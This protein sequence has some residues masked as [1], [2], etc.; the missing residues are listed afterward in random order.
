MGRAEGSGQ[1]GVSGRN[2]SV[3]LSC[4]ERVDRR[5]RFAA[6]AGRVRGRLPINQLT[7]F[8]R[9]GRL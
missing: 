7:G 8:V 4:G 5:R 6:G 2:E 9:R 3:A 1:N